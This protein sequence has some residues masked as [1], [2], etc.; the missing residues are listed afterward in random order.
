MVLIRRRVLLPFLVLGVVLVGG[1]AAS[2]VASTVMN[3]PS[4]L[5]GY[6][7]WQVV[8]GP[9]VVSPWAWQLCAA[10]PPGWD[11]RVRETYGPHAERYIRVYANDLA[12]SALVAGARPFPA[13]AMIAK[14]KFLVSDAPEPSG[15][16]FMV[17]KDDKELPNSSGWAFSYYPSRTADG[18][19][20]QQSCAA[21]HRTAAKADYVLG[22]YPKR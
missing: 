1:C 8:S 5:A 20:T 2:P 16:G 22:E 13:G 12:A 4:A 9:T 21:C 18:G 7:A 11:A 14:E 15:V 6:R 19:V 17:K 3:I 10:P